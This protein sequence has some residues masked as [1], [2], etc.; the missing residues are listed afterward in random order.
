MDGLRLATNRTFD[1]STGNDTTQTL[2]AL[3]QALF[4][5]G[6]TPSPIDRWTLELP[7]DANPCLASV[8]SLDTLQHD[9]GELADVLL[10]LEFQVD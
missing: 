5:G 10:A 9:L 6:A 7:L 3:G 1:V 2:N 8:S 4:G